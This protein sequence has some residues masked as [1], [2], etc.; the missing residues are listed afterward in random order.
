MPA[1]EPHVVNYIHSK[2][3]FNQTYANLGVG[4]ARQI[5]IQ[6]HPLPGM[7]SQIQAT[8]LWN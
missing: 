4:S 3:T 2:Y 5:A 8:L 7:H 6:P 1:F